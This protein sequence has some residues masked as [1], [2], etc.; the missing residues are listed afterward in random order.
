MRTRPIA[1]FAAVGVIG[2]LALTGCGNSSSSSSGGGLSG[3]SG[4][5]G[6]SS[7]GGKTYTVAFEGPLTGDNQ[8]LGINEVYGV[9]LAVAEANKN[10]S[11]GF[12]VKLLKADD[13]GDPSK[14]PAAAAQVLQNPNVMGV[15]GP[16]FSG[17]TSAVGKI[18]GKAGLTIVNPSA[19][20]GS[21]ETLGF[22]TWHRI[23]PN[24]FAEGPAAAKWLAKRSKKVYV[25]DDKSTYGK[26]VSDVVRK[27]LKAQGV[28]VTSQGVDAKTTDY[29]PAAQ[30]VKQSGVTAL[31]YG[32][33][34]A[35]AALF[36]KALV[37]AGFTGLRMSGNGVKST[38][39]TTGAAKAGYGWYFSC[40]CQDATVAPTAKAFTA[41]YTKMF[42]TPPST[43][44]PEA[45]DATNILIQAIKKAKA[46]GAVTKASVNAQVNKTDYTGITG[47]I[48]FQANGD[49]PPGSGTVNLFEDKN[50]KIV[51]L[52]DITK[53]K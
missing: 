49:I 53:A 3:G 46:A 7:G 52:G 21:L 24:D 10:P 27:T 25:I 18:Y 26:G 15:I 50:G 48:K 11:L 20:D 28:Q 6:S 5:S 13:V 43:Y 37:A 29:G 35:Q 36:A 44:S 41:A 45:Y 9:Q 47:R 42:N 19:S 22:A 31:F 51:S 16:S 2:A 17:A 30:A 34:D 32:G 39:F 14:A 12:K 8:Q 23:F 4:G 33:Y 40:G 38:V 1:K